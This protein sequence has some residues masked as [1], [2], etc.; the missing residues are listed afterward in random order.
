MG[1]ITLLNVPA[2]SDPLVHVLNDAGTL[3]VSHSKLTSTPMFAP[4]TWK[5]S[6]T[7]PTLWQV[8]T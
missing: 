1:T 5:K 3:R 7:R 6:G 4:G 8:L 2:T